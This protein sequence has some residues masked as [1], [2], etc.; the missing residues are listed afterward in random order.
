[1]PKTK[2]RQLLNK[3]YETAINFGMDPLQFVRAL[4][5]IPTLFRNYFTY[6]NASRNNQSIK[7]PLQL[8]DLR[9]RFHNYKSD[10]GVARGQYFYQDLWAARKIYERLP[11]HHVDVGSRVDGFIS[12]L[13][14]FMPVTV[15]D[16]RPLSSNVPGLTFIQEDATTLSSI[17]PHSVES[18]SSL[19]AIEHFGLGRYG[20]PVDPDACFKAMSSLARVLKAGGRL[21]FSVPIGRERLEF[22]AQRVFSP[23][24]IWL[25][26]A[27]E[28]GL[29][30]VSFSAV[31]D[32][33]RFHED[34]NPEEFVHAENSCGL[35][36]FTKREET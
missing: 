32:N 3:I 17:P 21:Y 12:H 34:V 25:V 15:I 29:D 20:D 7:F 27:K 8:R 22:N 31:D 4:K 5:G 33:G 1:M 16:I 28:L 18:L 10:A 36:E 6:A 13:L 11:S 30:I 24:T 2:T 23:R 26:Y 35:W 9:P 19:H 14:V